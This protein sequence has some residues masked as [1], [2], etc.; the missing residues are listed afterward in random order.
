MYSK[1]L[2]HHFWGNL[3]VIG[4]LNNHD[5]D[6]III[7]EPAAAAVLERVTE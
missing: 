1:L 4:S 3:L 2:P 6:V 5:L 7:G